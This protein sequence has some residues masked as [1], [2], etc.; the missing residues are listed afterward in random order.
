M[1][2]NSPA[3]LDKVRETLRLKHYSS[4]TEE[5]YLHWI[6][7]LLRYYHLRHPRELS[8]QEVEAFLANLAREQKVSASTQNQAVSALLFLYREVLRMELDIKIAVVRARQ[9][10][11]RPTVLTKAEAKAVLSQM[12]G[13]CGLDVTTTMTLRLRLPPNGG[14][15]ASLHSCAQSR[16]SCRAKSARLMVSSVER[17]ACSLRPSSAATRCGT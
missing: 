5:S 3:L 11:H 9:S 1:K 4:N 7:Q 15:V 10:R 12:S 6:R 14:Q 16:W 8:A 13:M 17:P 2:N